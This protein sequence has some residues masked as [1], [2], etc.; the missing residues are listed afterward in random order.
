M[1]NGLKKGVYVSRFPY[2]VYHSKSRQLSVWLTHSRDF[3]PRL[4]LSL[5]GFRRAFITDNSFTG[6]SY[7]F[8]PTV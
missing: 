2:F 8:P 1:A 3:P 6:E 4:Q 5:L 7:E